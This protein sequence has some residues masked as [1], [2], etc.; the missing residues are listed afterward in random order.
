MDEEEWKDLGFIPEEAAEWFYRGFDSPELAIGW[1]NAGI[2][3][4]QALLWKLYKF[5]VDEALI[6]QEI[7]LDPVMSFN[8]R[9]AEFIPAEVSCIIYWGINYM[10][11]I[12][13]LDSGR[14]RDEIMNKIYTENKI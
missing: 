10:D 13:A 11:I 9:A 2:E 5:N 14:N 7:G 12:E 6:W 4:E 3:P 1:R 8:W